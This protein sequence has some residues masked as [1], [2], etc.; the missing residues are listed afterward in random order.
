MK[1]IPREGTEFEIKCDTIISA[2]GQTGDFTG[3]EGL[4]G[5]R[6][7]IDATQTYQVKGKDMHLPVATSCARTF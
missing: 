4:D 1:P 3:L 7:F 2:I 6:G 5:G